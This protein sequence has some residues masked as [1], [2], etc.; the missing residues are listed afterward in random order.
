MGLVLELEEG[1][2]VYYKNYKKLKDM[3]RQRWKIENSFINN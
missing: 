2:E 1:E 3:S